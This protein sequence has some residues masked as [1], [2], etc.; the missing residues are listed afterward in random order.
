MSKNMGFTLDR[1]LSGSGDISMIG[2]ST[3]VS[4]GGQ[5]S[6]DKAVM[7]KKQQSPILAGREGYLVLSWVAF[8]SCLCLDKIMKWPCFVPMCYGLKV[9]LSDVSALR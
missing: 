9:A 7:V 1:T 8:C 6:E 2:T 4:I 3:N 5:T